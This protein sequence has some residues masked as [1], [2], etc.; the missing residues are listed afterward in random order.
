MLAIADDV[1]MQFLDFLSTLFSR[2]PLRKH[3]Y[4][5]IRSLSIQPK[6]CCL[7]LLL[8]RGPFPRLKEALRS[9]PG[10]DTAME[11]MKGR[12]RGWAV[13]MQRRVSRLPLKSLKGFLPVG[14]DSWHGGCIWCIAMDLPGQFELCCLGSETSTALNCGIACVFGNAM[15]P[16][17][18]VARSS[19]SL[20]VHQGRSADHSKTKEGTLTEFNL[21]LQVLR[22]H[23]PSCANTSGAAIATC[24][25]HACT[26]KEQ[27]TH[28]TCHLS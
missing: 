24:L 11:T 1:D 23:R 25:Q 28:L 2:V 26:G 5:D 4:R 20:C 22:Q 16:M 9:W 27:L 15:F 18:A 13:Y 7:S 12:K 3:V 21:I 17:P 6:G 10:S 8:L 19:N 14:L